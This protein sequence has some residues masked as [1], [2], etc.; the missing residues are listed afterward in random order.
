MEEKFRKYLVEALKIDPIILKAIE[1]SGHKIVKKDF[2]FDIKFGNSEKTLSIDG[3]FV[4]A[5]RVIRRLVPDLTDTEL[6]VILGDL[7]A[8]QA[9]KNKSVDITLSNKVTSGYNKA[10]KEG[11]V[12]SC[13]VGMKSVTKFYDDNPNIQIALL[14]QKGNVVARALVW[15]GVIDSTG[16]ELSYMDRVY[17]SSNKYMTLMH[18][19]CNENGWIYRGQNAASRND[20]S[21]G[22]QIFFDVDFEKPIRF[23]WM[24]TLVYAYPSEGF[25]TNEEVKDAAGRRTVIQSTGGTVVEPEGWSI[26]KIV[27]TY[28]KHERKNDDGEIEIHANVDLSRQGLTVIPKYFSGK[29]IVGNFDMS[30]NDLRTLKNAPRVVTGKFDVFFN[31]HLTTLKGGPE[32]V[33][34]HYRAYGCDLT[35]LVGSPHEVGRS[36]NISKNQ[37][38]KSLVGGPEKVGYRYWAHTCGLKS[39]EGIASDIKKEDQCRFDGNAKEFTTGDI[40][41]AINKRFDKQRDVDFYSDEGFD[42]LDEKTSVVDIYSDIL[43]G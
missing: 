42:D 16:K 43:N 7:K 14:R 37:H 10:S 2:D 12:N 24:D 5:G 30:R 3:D 33:G 13:M 32:I 9:T 23:P 1:K 36:F 17:P 27:K 40:M 4:R 21:S 19:F 11:H 38:L 34:N 20:I 29:I 25:I 18:S 35:S 39:L 28:K 31:H 15:H 8:H 26:K 6:N 22:K 41:N